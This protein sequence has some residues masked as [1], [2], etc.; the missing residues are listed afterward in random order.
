VS[1]QIELASSSGQVRVVQ[2][3]PR[4]IADLA[5]VYDYI[6]DMD[7]SAVKE[8]LTSPGLASDSPIE[9]IHADF[10]ELHY[11]RWLFLRRK[12]EGQLLPPTRDI[13]ILWHAHIL[14]TYRYHED[15]E[16]VFGYYFHHYP[17]FGVRGDEDAANFNR[18]FKQ[19]AVLYKEEFAVDL[20]I[21]V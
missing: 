8:M 16:L 3:G 15:C 18:A 7:F 2:P 19:M 14:D 5:A 9:E 12:Y 10:C 21:F 1:A 17:Y 13:D 11:K 4:R 20:P 6:S